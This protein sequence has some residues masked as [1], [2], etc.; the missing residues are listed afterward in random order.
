MNEKIKVL[1]V[2]INHYTAK[3]AMQKGHGIYGDRTDQCDRD[4]DDEYVVAA[5]EQR[6]KAIY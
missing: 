4:G 6:R 5:F 3:E 1:G 2:S